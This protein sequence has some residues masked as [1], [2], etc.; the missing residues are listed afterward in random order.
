MK[1]RGFCDASSIIENATEELKKHTQ[2]GF[3]E[4]FQHI[5]N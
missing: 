4:Y 1:V 5:Q 3:Q 2:N